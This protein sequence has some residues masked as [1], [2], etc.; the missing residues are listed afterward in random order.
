MSPAGINL[1]I[2]ETGVIDELCICDI[3]VSAQD[4]NVYLT[5]LPYELSL[6]EIANAA[7]KRRQRVFESILRDD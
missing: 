7:F 1:G 4:V 5:P 6:P 3:S 2:I